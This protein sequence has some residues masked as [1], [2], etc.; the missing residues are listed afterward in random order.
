MNIKDV[1]E[2]SLVVFKEGPIHKMK[3][4]PATIIESRANN[5]ELNKSYV[6]RENFL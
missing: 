5:L 3:S 1:A 6:L 2:Y 4:V